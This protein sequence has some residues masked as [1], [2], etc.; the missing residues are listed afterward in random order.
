MELIP[1]DFD[2]LKRLG[3]CQLFKETFLIFFQKKSL[4]AEFGS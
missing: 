1:K 2:L 3:M 4:F